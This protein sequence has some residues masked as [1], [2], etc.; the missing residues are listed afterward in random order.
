MLFR[1]CKNSVQCISLNTCTSGQNSR[2]TGGK[3]IS[4][5][6]RPLPEGKI[7]GKIHSCACLLLMIQWMLC[8]C[9]FP[10]TKAVHFPPGAKKIEHR[11][12]VP[13]FAKLED[14][15]THQSSWQ[16]RGREDAFH[17]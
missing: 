1:S 11:P 7:E 10:S 15:W 12:V 5:R 16:K 8:T 9:L 3:G 2:E 4:S 17:I 13:Y 14:L 6:V